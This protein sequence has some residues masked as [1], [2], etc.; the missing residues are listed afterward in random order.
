MKKTNKCL[1][2]LILS[3]PFFL[4]S[5]SKKVNLEYTDSEGVKQSLLVEETE[6]KEEVYNVIVALNNILEEQEDDSKLETI[7]MGINFDAELE[8]EGEN[9]TSIKLITDLVVSKEEKASAKAE[10][11]IKS[12]TKEEGVSSNTS[13]DFKGE[14][15]L[16]ESGIYYDIALNSGENKTEL[17]QT[18]SMAQI[19]TI[20]Q[21]LMS[22]LAPSTGNPMMPSLD[23]PELDN[24]EEIVEL[25]EEYNIVISNTSR[26]TI[27]FKA[28]LPLHELL[29]DGSEGVV[30]VYLEL[31]YKHVAPLS[32][33]FDTKALIT[34]A[35]KQEEIINGKIN[36]E[37]SFKYNEV[38][39]KTLTDEQ[40]KGFAPFDIS[41]IFQ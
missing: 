16:D 12:D 9:K 22:N 10:L 35:I 23:F 3:L 39:V 13:V 2:L 1:L 36:L 19:E 17:K 40:K 34:E 30:D 18:I 21:Q 5:C 27:T 6:N 25:L 7:F 15:F 31:D 29:A 14:L 38:K 37:I 8:L 24:K 28:G 20:I 41:N 11:N 26:K 33:K 32:I 4:A